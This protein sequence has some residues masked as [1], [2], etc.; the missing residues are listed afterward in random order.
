MGRKLPPYR[1]MSRRVR[2]LFGSLLLLAAF[3]LPDRSHSSVPCNRSRELIPRDCQACASPCESPFNGS[4]CLELRIKSLRRGGG[5]PSIRKDALGWPIL[6]VLFFAR[7]G[8]RGCATPF[9]AIG[10][11]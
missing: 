2:L 9:S 4:F 3:R 11:G 7:A 5:G 1:R 10:R 6:A 8:L